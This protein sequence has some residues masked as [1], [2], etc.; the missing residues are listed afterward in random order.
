MFNL[1]DGSKVLNF[2]LITSPLSLPCLSISGFSLVKYNPHRVSHQFELDQDVP[3][4]NDM[5]YDVR[6]AMRPLLYDSAMDYWHEREVNV[7][8]LCRQRKG[9]VTQNMCTYWWK[10]MNS[11]VDFVAS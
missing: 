11:F 3:T 4:I 8:I 6:E 5:E 1:G 2:L 7:L 10:I 9:C